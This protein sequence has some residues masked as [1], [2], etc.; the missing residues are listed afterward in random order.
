VMDGDGVVRLEVGSI[1][2]D[3]TIVPVTITD[4]NFQLHAS[5]CDNPPF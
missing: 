4:G 1:L 5:S 2:D 3:G